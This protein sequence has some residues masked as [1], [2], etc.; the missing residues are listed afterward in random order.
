MKLKKFV[1]IICLSLTWCI[2]FYAQEEDLL[3]AVPPT[4]SDGIPEEH[5]S[6]ENDAYYEGYIQALVNSHYYEYAER[7]IRQETASL[8]SVADVV[9]IKGKK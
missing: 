2:S 6:G 5:L 4:R 9:S 3:C 7:R 1:I 8:L